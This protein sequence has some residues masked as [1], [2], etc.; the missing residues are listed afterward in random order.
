M[1][2]F[3]TKDSATNAAI[4]AQK[5]YTKAVAVKERSPE[6]LVAGWNQAL[7]EILAALV[8]DLKALKL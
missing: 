4:V 6:A 1:E 2:F 3:L 5:R 7:S 8:N